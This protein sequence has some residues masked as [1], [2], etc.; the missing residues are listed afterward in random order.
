MSEREQADVLPALVHI[1]EAHGRN[2]RE[3]VRAIVSS[4]AYRRID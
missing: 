4:P 3:L 2:Y 1:F